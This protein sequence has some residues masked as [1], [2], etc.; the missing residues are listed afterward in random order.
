LGRAVDALGRLP[1]CEDEGKTHQAPDRLSYRG[2]G[3]ATEPHV[4]A[5]QWGCGTAKGC[6]VG[7][8]GSAEGEGHGADPESGLPAGRQAQ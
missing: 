2:V 7:L 4:L 6:Q 5:V 8:K 3:R 1:E